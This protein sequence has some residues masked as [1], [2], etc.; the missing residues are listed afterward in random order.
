MR[1]IHSP[2]RHLDYRN[3]LRPEERADL[4]DPEVWPEL[5]ALL[6]ENEHLRRIVVQLSKLVISNVVDRK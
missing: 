4:D 3:D 5:D 2:T 6:E 1:A